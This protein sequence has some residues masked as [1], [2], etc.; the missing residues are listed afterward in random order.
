MTGLALALFAFV[1]HVATSGRYGYFRDELYFIAC[2]HHLAWGYVDQPPLVALAAW[3]SGAFAYAL[4]ALRVLPA[5]AAAATVWVIC[6]LTRELGG[7]W[8]AELLAGLGVALMP[9]YLLLGNTLTTTSFEPLSWSL[10]AWLIVRMIRTGERRLFLAVGLAVAFGLYGKYS[11]VLLVVAVSAGLLLTA[12]RRVLKTWWLPAAAALA[13]LL[14]AP[15]LL[16]QARHA[17]PMLTVLHGDVLNRHAFNNGLTLEYKNVARNAAAFL[18]EQALF[19]NPIFVPLWICGTVSLLFGRTLRS[20]RALG[21]AYV[22]LLVLAVALMAKGYYIIGIYGTLLAAGAVTLERLWQVRV[23]LRG[24]VI[25]VAVTLTLPLLPLSIPLLPVD[26]LV[27][28]SA[29]L[30]LTGRDGTPPRLFQPLFAEE[31]GWEELTA[32]VARVY[33]SLPPAARVRTGLFADTYGD[34]AALA[35]YGPRYGL[36]PVISGQNTYYLWGTHGYSGETMIAVGAMQAEILKRSFADVRLVATYG[37]PYKWVVEGPAP[38]YLCTHPRA[39]LQQ[40]WPRFKW[41]GA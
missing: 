2:A 30:G 17:W 14:L 39:P 32:Q 24:V 22:V 40:L 5:L 34:A 4:V 18:V 11:M 38:I 20:Y 6:R 13:L 15:N 19:T 35:F 31:F 41:Y 12:E 21:I 7:G 25:A 23:A 28:Y 37:S 36:P 26:T 29:A 16:W 1:L 3:L 33:H 9:A 27:A 8:F 10:L